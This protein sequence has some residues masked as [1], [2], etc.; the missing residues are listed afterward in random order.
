MASAICPSWKDGASTAWSAFV[1]CSPPGSADRPSSA[2]PRV[3]RGLI[4]L[5]ESGTA[6]AGGQGG[7]G[8]ALGLGPQPGGDGGVASPAGR[9]DR[10]RGSDE[11]EPPA[12]TVVA[13]VDRRGVGGRVEQRLGARPDLLRGQDVE[14]VERRPLR[15]VPAEAGPGRLQVGA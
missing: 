10:R 8:E 3:N 1:T 4:R 15:L 5:A 7:T 14:A 9:P 11:P 13:A 2:A 6:S 12:R